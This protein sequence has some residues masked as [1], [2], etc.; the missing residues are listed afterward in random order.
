MQIVGEIKAKLH[1][2]DIRK[3]LEEL[4]M[5]NFS[6]KLFLYICCYYFLHTHPPYYPTMRQRAKKSLILF[7]FCFSESQFKIYYDVKDMFSYF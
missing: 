4:F 2:R 1:S 7:L 3:Q 5:Y 6:F